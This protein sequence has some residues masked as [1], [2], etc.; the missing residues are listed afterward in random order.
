M[1]YEWVCYNIT[2]DN[3]NSSVKLNNEG[4]LSLCHLPY[5]VKMVKSRKLRWAYHVARIEEGGIAFKILTGK[6]TG[7]DI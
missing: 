7:K 2:L 1:N 5:A 6:P 3:S 4:L